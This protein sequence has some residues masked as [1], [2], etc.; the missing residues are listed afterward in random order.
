MRKNK[1]EID[2]I[3]H[4]L[5]E[6]CVSRGAK[7]YIENL[8]PCF[9]NEDV[10]ELLDQVTFAKQLIE[11]KSKPGFYPFCDPENSLKRAELGGVLS[12]QELLDIALLLKTSKTVLEYVETAE[13]STSVLSKY[14]DHLQGDNGLLHSLETAILSEDEL[15]DNASNEL[16][17]IRRKMISLNSKTREFLNKMIS[18]DNNYLQ[19]NV[20]T[21]RNDRFVVPVKTEHKGAVNGFIHDVS[22]S[23]STL[24][25]EPL[26]VLEANN[27]LR[28]LKDQEQKEIE[29]ILKSFSDNVKSLARTLRLDFQV[30]TNLDFIFAKASLSISQKAVAPILTEN[31]YT[32]LKNAVHPLLD[33]DTAVAVTIE[34]GGEFDTLIITG[35]NTGGKTVCLKTFGLLTHMTSLGLHIP[36]SDESQIYIGGKI[37]ADIG[38]EQSIGENLSTFSSHMTNIIDIISKAKQGDLV[39]FDELGSGTDPLE[40]SA[41]AVA[42]IEHCRSLGLR[43]IATTHYSD[44]KLYALETDGVCNASFEF[45]METLS[46]TYNLILGSPGKSNAFEISRRLG[47][48]DRIIDDAKKLLSSEHNRFETIIDNLEKDRKSAYEARMKADEMRVLAKHTLDRAIKKEQ[49]SDQKYDDMVEKARLQGVRMLDE[50]KKTSKQVFAQLEDMK[51]SAKV[52]AK[53]ANL[54]KAREEIYKNLTETEKKALLKKRK[55]QT[56]AVDKSQLKIGV[57]VRLLATNNIAT[58]IQEP[59]KN[60]KIVC[61]AGILKITAKI[62]EIEIFKPYNEKP[63]KKTRKMPSKNTRELRNNPVS[64]EV[65]I[66]G[67]D[68]LEGIATVDIFIS[69]AIMSNV[70]QAYIIHGKGTGVLK[71]AIR[72]HLRHYKQIKGYRAGEFGEGE[73]GVTVITLK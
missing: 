12:L 6:L 72:N 29:Q 66:R 37:F 13:I 32:L 41:L 18:K 1:L 8:S 23:G 63:L 24:F 4:K 3:L 15:S 33:S 36:C 71:D 43:V 19:E 27:E 73:D 61:K 60:G 22:S 49:S 57:E 2:V 62:D 56:Q 47:L 44:I 10:Q 7:S 25:I 54:N 11:N 58:I 30:L 50:A 16:F 38:D 40:G 55:E 5:S 20:I 59:D 65:D 34:L 46:P 17:N 26:E 52:D 53:S 69:N 67:M 14:F 21:I 68:S 51:K 48:S 31:R 35:P 28:L 9:E 70:D 64:R 42:I 45:D 39:L